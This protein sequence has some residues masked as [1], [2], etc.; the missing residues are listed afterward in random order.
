MGLDKSSWKMV[1]SFAFVLACILLAS[2]PGVQ[3]AALISGPLSGKLSESF[4]RPSGKNVILFDGVCNFCNRWVNFV[5]DNDPNGIFCFASMQSPQ[6]RQILD[7]CG[8]PDDLSTFLLVD[9]EGFWTQSTAAL[10]VAA[11]LDPMLLRR[12]GASFQNVPLFLRD[13]LYRVVADNRYSILGRMD[14]GVTPSCQLK[15]DY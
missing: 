5:I 15:Y 13:G 14:D 8:R 1:S 2:W 4:Q 6:G 10:R 7:A 9:E 12:A 3:T 11:N